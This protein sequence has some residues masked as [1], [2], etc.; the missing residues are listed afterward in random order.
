M[1]AYFRIFILVALALSCSRAPRTV[2][3]QEGK[4]D[5]QVREM[6]NKLMAGAEQGAYAVFDFDQTSIVHDISQALWVYQIEQL[7]YAD[8]PAHHFL[9]G[10][11]TPEDEMPGAGVSFAE[12]GEVLA[13]EY[14]AL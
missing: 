13:A 10:V 11:P 14:T 7:R 4:W 2:A 12:M 5:P 6:L 1:K 3:L 8:A 9:D